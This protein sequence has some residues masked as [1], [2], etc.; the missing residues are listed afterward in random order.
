VPRVHSLHIYPVKSLGVVD[1]D[2]AEVTPTGLAHDRGWVVCRPDGTFL[3]QRQHARMALIA[4]RPTDDGLVLEHAGSTLTVPRPKA[5]APPITVTVWRDAVPCRRASDAAS[6]W[7]SAILGVACVLAFQ[8]DPASRRTDPAWDSAAG[9]VSLADGFPLL[10]ASTASLAD[11]QAHIAT[12]LPM[13]RFRP[14]IVIAD[15]TP[16]AED[17]WRRIAIGRAVLRIVKPC[18][19]CIITTIDQTTAERPDPREPLSALAR[20]RRAEGGVMFGQNA[21]VERAGPIA[22]GDTVRVL[23][24]GPANLVR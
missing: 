16:W 9:H 12:A 3:T 17:T 15:A 19:R 7:L 1:L 10:L 11:L 14:N 6:A 22:V 24:T 21:V 20:F 4:A 13:N 8:H 5:D 18:S 23:E 2:G